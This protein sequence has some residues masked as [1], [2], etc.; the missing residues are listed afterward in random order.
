MPRGFS[1]SS[2]HRPLTA[3][4]RGD[5]GFPAVVRI[6]SAPSFAVSSRCAA[7]FGA[8][9]EAFISGRSLSH[10]RFI[11]ACMSRTPLVIAT[12]ASYCGRTSMYCPNAPSP[13]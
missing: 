9:G 3:L 13:R 2:Y 6:V 1:A 4:A 10:T 8:S 7:A 12:T 11:T 5:V